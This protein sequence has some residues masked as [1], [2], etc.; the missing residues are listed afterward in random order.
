M[1]ELGREPRPPTSFTFQPRGHSPPPSREQPLTTNSSWL[2]GMLPRRQSSP[3]P[4]P[5]EGCT[6]TSVSTCGLVT[7]TPTLSHLRRGLWGSIGERL[8]LAAGSQILGHSRRLTWGGRM[9]YCINQEWQRHTARAIDIPSGCRPYLAGFRQGATSRVEHD[10]RR[11][12]LV[13]NVAAPA[14][15]ETRGFVDNF[16]PD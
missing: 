10:K 12:C 13:A 15:I 3:P 9:S 2:A 11:T 1:N 16:T 6:L 5:E 7:N 8:S 4:P 14:S